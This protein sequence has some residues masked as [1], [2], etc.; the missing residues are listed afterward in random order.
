M[1]NHIS[2]DYDHNHE[3]IPNF[4]KDKPEDII[5]KKVCFKHLAEALCSKLDFDSH[6]DVGCGS[7]YL[8]LSMRDRGKPSFGSEVGYMYRHGLFPE[9]KN[10][11]YET[12]IFELDSIGIKFDLVSAMEV[13]EHI[14]AE[15]FYK[16]D[17]N[18]AIINLISSSKRYIF[19][20]MPILTYEYCPWL[21]WN[22]RN[23]RFWPRI[24]KSEEVPLN[25]DKTPILGHVTLATEAWWTFKLESFGLKRMIEAEEHINMHLHGIEPGLLDWWHIFIYKK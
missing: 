16:N 10:F 4:Q 21:D 2:V 23:P 14:Y 19:L 5:Y 18:D 9:I 13:L 24:L 25:K 22:G 3:A 6:L 7:G 12:S 8:I 1:K 17:L 11:V 20:T 15:N